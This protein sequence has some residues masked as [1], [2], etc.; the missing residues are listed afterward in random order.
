[1]RAATSGADLVVAGPE[2]DLA[3]PGT[4]RFRL[5]GGYT[6]VCMGNHPKPAL[7]SGGLIDPTR[8]RRLRVARI[9]QEHRNG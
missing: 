4:V 2:I 9:E 5:N 1:M 3:P 6:L 7:A 8:L